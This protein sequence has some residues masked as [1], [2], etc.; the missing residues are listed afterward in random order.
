[1]FKFC[2]CFLKKVNEGE[3]QLDQKSLLW[4]MPAPA[5]GWMVRVGKLS[6]V[7]LSDGLKN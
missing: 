4:K 1:M 2:L 6:H 3:D 5:D 7:P